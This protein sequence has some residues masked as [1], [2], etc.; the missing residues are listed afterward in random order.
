[1]EVKPLYKTIPVIQN[2]KFSAPSILIA[3]LGTVLLLVCFISIVVLVARDGNESTTLAATEATAATT[4]ATTAIDPEMENLVLSNSINWLLDRIEALENQLSER[5]QPNVS[6]PQTRNLLL[7]RI[8][9]LENQLSERSQL[10]VSNLQPHVEVLTPREGDKSRGE[11]VRPPQQE[12]KGQASRE[13][14]KPRDEG[15][16]P[17][18]RVEV[19]TPREGDKPRDE[20]VRPPP[21]EKKGQASR[22]GDKPRGEGVRPPPRENNEST[23]RRPP[24]EKK[25]SPPREKR[26]ATQGAPSRAKKG[27][28]RRR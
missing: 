8:E 26:G 1:M 24:Q 23:Q 6:N 2:T 10:N 12:K 21:E 7:D 25:G 28:Q 20:G 22:E 16:R 17:Q 19:L 9:A 15:V 18:P 3:L 13:G 5:P 11:G 27:Q 4:W 14:D